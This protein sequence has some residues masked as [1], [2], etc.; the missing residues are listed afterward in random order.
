[1]FRD[2]PKSAATTISR[3]NPNTRLQRTASPDNAGRLGADA[4]LFS[5][6]HG[7]ERTAA[8]ESN[9][10]LQPNL[11]SILR[12]LQSACW[13]GPL[14]GSLRRE[15]ALINERS[16]NQDNCHA[17]ESTDA[18][19]LV[20]VTQVVEEKFSEGENEKRNPGVTQAK[21]CLISIPATIRPRAKAAQAM[22]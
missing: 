11:Q 20:Q 22:E 9:A 19:E 17:D 13:S 4:F 7:Q 15:E 18:V 1:M 21:R 8:S 12:R 2:A 14:S 16:R 6:G 5:L 10:S 3:I